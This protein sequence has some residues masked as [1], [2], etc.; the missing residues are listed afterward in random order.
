[1][2]EPLTRRLS[3]LDEVADLQPTDLMLLQRGDAP[4][5]VAPVQAMMT[6]LEAAGV[7]AVNA[8]AAIAAKDLAV[9]ARNE[10]QTART[11]AEAAAVLAQ[12]A[13]A[14]YHPFS[15]S[16]AG[17]DAERIA[18]MLLVGPDGAAL[19]A[20]DYYVKYNARTAANTYFMNVC[21]V[22]DDAVVT[23]VGANGTAM[24]PTGFTGLRT[25]PVVDCFGLGIT[26][27]VRNDFGDGS[28][29]GTLA[30]PI[31]PAASRLNNDKVVFAS[32]E[33]SA[34]IE[35]ISAPQATLAVA[36]SRVFLPT[37]ADYP[38]DWVK[39]AWIY[40]AD[41]R[42]VGLS[43]LETSTNRV[44]IHVTDWDSGAVVAQGG[45]NGGVNPID[46]ATLRWIKLYTGPLDG[47][48]AEQ[49]TGVVVVLEVDPDK[50]VIAPA[51]T[52]TE[53]ADYDAAGFLP[54]HVYPFEAQERGLREAV[55]E[56]YLTVADGPAFAAA[57]ATLYESLPT[58]APDENF[59]ANVKTVRCHNQHPIAIAPA[60]RG[61]T[62]TFAAAVVLGEWMGVDLRGGTIVAPPSVAGGLGRAFESNKSGIQR[63]GVIRSWPSAPEFS[64]Y[65]DHVDSVNGETRPAEI[66]E[67]VQQKRILKAFLR[68]CYDLGEHHQTWGRGVGFPSGYREYNEDCGGIRRNPTS[69]HPIW[70]YHNSPGSTEPALIWHVGSRSQQLRGPS[71][72]VLTQAVQTGGRN[73][74][75]L[76]DCDPFYVAHGCTIPTADAAM[77]DL[78]ADRRMT[79]IIG[80]HDGPVSYEDENALV[81]A[82]PLGS[83]VS[84][85]AVAVLAGQ[86]DGGGYGAKLLLDGSIRSMG[87]RLA[88][89]GDVTITVNGVNH[90]FTGIN[91][92][93]TAA[94]I[95]AAANASL[96]AGV[97]SLG[98]AD[99]RDFADTGWKRLAFP[100]G[101]V[102]I[103]AGRMVTR[104]GPAT[105]ALAGPGDPI[106]GW[107]L[108]PVIVGVGG[109]VVTQ[110][111]VPRYYL[112]EAVA[113]GPFGVD[114]GGLIDYA[115]AEKIGAVEGVEGAEGF[116][117]WWR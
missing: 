1:M 37:A 38:R 117:R 21:R 57:A 103:A 19:Y 32:P 105:V 100:D 106:F 23:A 99:R 88:A 101:G 28:N 9:T 12:A 50:V 98:R 39:G 11:G 4:A 7:G 48:S 104:T 82:T 65:G 10:S 80:R 54:E 16:P 75:I 20:G 60:A 47:A 97:L 18:D 30:A 107:T 3:Q 114:A 113:D 29:F 85:T 115:A 87:A 68:W 81:L 90:L 86:V 35:R 13:A 36:R 31:A 102:A 53:Y 49:F 62:L 63:D 78:A 116:I 2:A 71:I 59:P 17:T 84:G 34:T 73:Q 8:A 56:E 22:S 66:G 14:R 69:N 27:W 51:P 46:Y 79:D 25:V 44:R 109:T 6:F 24:D 5:Q 108:T 76:R 40:M 112:P 70:G 67:A 74:L 58:G 91:P 89:A 96:G 41:R 93:A 111:I 15:G 42:R 61:A 52:A 64:A 43:L 72:V 110:K 77:P 45:P 26:G 95:L 83:V 94:A 92:A 33:R 55:F